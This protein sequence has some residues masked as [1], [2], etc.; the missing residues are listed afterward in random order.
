V[1][2]CPRVLLQFG[3]GF[4]LKIDE[5]FSWLL[6]YHGEDALRRHRVLV[7]LTTKRAR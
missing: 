3:L 4:E 5:H 1:A 6:E 7:G 2:S